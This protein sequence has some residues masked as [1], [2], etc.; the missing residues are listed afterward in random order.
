MG[1]FETSRDR[2]TDPVTDLAGKGEDNSNISVKVR[3]K[4]DKNGVFQGVMINDE[5]GKQKM[6]PMN[7]WNKTFEY[8]NK[9]TF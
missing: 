2:Q 9:Q 8:E 6:I 3:I 4:T 7:N 5:K 1:N